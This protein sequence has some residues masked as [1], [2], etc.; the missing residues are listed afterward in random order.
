MVPRDNGVACEYYGILE[1]MPMVKVKFGWHRSD[2]LGVKSS[3]TGTEK[4]RKVLPAL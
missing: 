2:H 1:A 3:I 4:V